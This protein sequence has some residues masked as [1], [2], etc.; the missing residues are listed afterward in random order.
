MDSFKKD[1]YKIVDQIYDNLFNTVTDILNS[2]FEKKTMK[3]SLIW[4]L[5]LTVKRQNQK[6][7][8]KFVYIHVYMPFI[9]N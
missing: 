9:S 5:V 7:T 6:N 8:W 3:C 1:I 4:H 2:N